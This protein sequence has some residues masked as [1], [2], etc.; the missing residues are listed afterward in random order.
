MS[1]CLDNTTTT[2]LKQGFRQAIGYALEKAG[3]KL[4]YS[5]ENEAA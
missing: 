2:T 5:P 3:K 4:V 1:T